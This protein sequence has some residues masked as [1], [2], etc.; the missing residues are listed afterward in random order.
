MLRF[1]CDGRPKGTL[2]HFY[3]YAPT[4][5]QVPSYIADISEIVVVLENTGTEKFTFGW[6]TH[7]LNG[8]SITTIAG[9]QLPAGKKYFSHLYLAPICYAISTHSI[10]DSYTADSFKAAYISNLLKTDEVNILE[11]YKFSA[12]YGSNAHGWIYCK[13]KGC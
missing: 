8:K 4:P 7:V 5:I 11:K 1:V 3:R 12:G 6:M 13:R 10:G 2:L 9:V